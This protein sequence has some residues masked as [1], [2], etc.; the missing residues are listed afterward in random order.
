MVSAISLDTRTIAQL[1]E[2]GKLRPDDIDHIVVDTQG[3]ELKVLQGI[4][5]ALLEQTSYMA[6]EKS[7]IEIY[8]HQD[9]LEGINFFLLNVVI[10]RYGN[11]YR[12]IPN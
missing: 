1:I 7:K 2:G 9:L 3:T 11:Q 10:D 6:L 5:A 12:L 4:P 8:E